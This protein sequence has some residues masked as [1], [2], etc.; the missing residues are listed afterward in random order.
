MSGIDEF[1]DCENA[2]LCV[3]IYRA[4]NGCQTL[5]EVWSTGITA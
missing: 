2:E 1:N 5:Y 3:Y 4:I